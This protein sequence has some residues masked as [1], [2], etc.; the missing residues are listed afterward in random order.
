MRNKKDS[1]IGVKFIKNTKPDMIT[2]LEGALHTFVTPLVNATIHG[3]YQWQGYHSIRLYG[4]AQ[5]FQLGRRV[6]M[7]ALVQQDFEGARVMLKV[8]KAEDYEI[9]GNPQ[10][11]QILSGSAKQDNQ[12]RQEYDNQIRS[13]LVYHLTTARKLPPFSTARTGAIDL[14]E[15]LTLLSDLIKNKPGYEIPSSL[16]DCFM[17]LGQEWVISLEIMFKTALHQVKNELY[18]LEKICPQQGY[19]YTFNPPVIFVRLFESQGTGQG[20]ELLTHIQVAAL[21]YLCSWMP[22]NACRSVAWNDFSSPTVISLLRCAF[23]NKPH[24]VIKRHEDIFP[25]LGS[26]E[27]LYAAP[28]GSKSSMLVIHNNSDAFGQNIETEASGGSLDGVI[29][30]YSSAAASLH[31]NRKDLCDHMIRV[32]A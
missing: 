2:N 9:I 25:H 3:D 28:E 4:P 14:P 13:F 31:R 1:A 20:S 15:T 23:A 22:L 16:E 12:L 30:S 24:I 5:G 8:V 7:S 21:K 17:R 18:G 29:G 19:V 6:I 27:G 11:P 10:F 26:Q 32:P